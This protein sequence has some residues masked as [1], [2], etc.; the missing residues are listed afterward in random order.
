[1]RHL[2]LLTAFIFASALSAQCS[3]NVNFTAAYCSEDLNGFFLEFTVVSD[4]DSVWEAPQLNMSGAIN[5]GELFIAGPLPLSQQNT[6]IVFLMS[7]VP[8][9]VEV[10][11]PPEISCPGESC[12]GLEVVIVSNNGNSFCNDSL[13]YS[14]Q[15]LG[16]NA[17]YRLEVI[18]AN[19]V[20]VLLDEENFG[21]IGSVFGE[22]DYTVVATDEFDCEVNRTFT[23]LENDCAS[24]QGLSWLDNNGNGIREAEDTLSVNAWVALR[25][26]TGGFVG[27]T[28]TLSDGSYAFNGIMP[29]RTYQVS[30]TPSQGNFDLVAQ[31]VGNDLTV[32]SDF[33][34]ATNSSS[35]IIPQS[36]TDVL[37]IDAGWLAVPCEWNVNIDSVYCDETGD[38]FYVRF[39]VDGSGNDLW[40]A[41]QL[42]TEGEYGADF[43]RTEGPFALGQFT[44]ITFIDQNDDNCQITVPLP[45]VTCEDNPCFNNSFSIEVFQV[46][47]DQLCGTGELFIDISGESF[48]VILEFSHEATGEVISTT[49]NEPQQ[50]FFPDLPAG[51][52]FGTASNSAG[53]IRDFEI[54]LEESNNLEVGI[55]QQGS[56]CSGEDV[57]LIAEAFIGGDLT[58]EW[59]TGET[60]QLINVTDFNNPTYTV[61]VT[62]SD[63]CVGTAFFVINVQQQD[64]IDIPSVVTLSCDGSPTTIT[65]ANPVEGFTYQW[66]G[67][68]NEVLTG[69]S[70]ETDQAGFFEV[71]GSNGVGCS[72]FG[73]TQVIDLSLEEV[74]LEAT[75]IDS[76]CG[77]QFCFGLQNMNIFNSDLVDIT[78]T[79]PEEFNEWNETINVDWVSICVPWEGLYTVTVETEC[80]TISLSFET[81]NNSCSLISG[82][83]YLDADGDCDL[84]ADDIPAPGFIL[85]LT[86]DV[87]G[88]MYYAWTDADGNWA[89][90]LPLGTYTVEPI[91]EDGQPLGTCDPAT[92][93]T[94]GS[95]AVTGVQVFMPVL[96]NCP[97]L[98]TEVTIPFLRRC[99]TGCA[100]VNYENIGAGLAEDAQVV[101]VLDPFF[102]D[103]APSVAPVSVVGNVYTFNLGDLPPFSDGRIGFIFTVSCDAEIGQSHCIDASITPDDPCFPHEEWQGALVDITSAVCDGD[104]VT[105]TVTN[106]GDGQM[107]IPLNYVIVE[108]G[109]MLSA[110][111][112]TNGQLTPGEAFEITME[113]NG[114]TY[115]VITNQEPNAPG[116]DQP[117]AAAEGCNGGGENFST[118]FANILPLQSGNPAR[119]IVCRENVGSWDPNDKRGYP[120][121]WDDGNIEQGTRLDYEIRF[122]NTGTDTAFTVVI[123]D[124]LEESLDL[125]TFKM[126]ASSHDYTVT[127]DTHRVVS[128]TFENIMLPDSNANLLLSQGS[129][130]FS[131]DHDP[132]L[133]G[134][135]VILNEAAIYFD[136]N[137]PVIT[138]VSRHVIAKDG[139]PVG[140]RAITAQTIS[141]SIYPNPANDLINLKVPNQDIQ[142]TDVLTVTDL[143]GRALLSTTYGQLGRGMDISSLPA[144]YYLMLISD[145]SG[146]VMGRSGFVVAKN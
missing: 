57:I 55:V 115:A 73:F 23:V 121:G 69:T 75:N 116:N 48:P 88:A 113:A 105:F 110:Q 1:M 129:V 60:T 43:F 86:D 122:Q 4:Q 124:T 126:E 104:T 85:T 63:G 109:I 61:T 127:I 56:P 74:T 90:E 38:G 16:G 138:N 140:L 44:E 32:D 62:S 67:N 26:E 146:Q 98:Q 50:I 27:S 37:N 25:D 47:E 70:V 2:L 30:I 21:Q 145:Q 139:L 107:T 34:P 87:T 108:D 3:L 71:F 24:I 11:T 131:I 58:F 102:E 99:F 39:S 112:L 134:G 19:G 33:N 45:E 53:C 22:G 49:F 96:A 92:N 65:I 35:F 9:C 83:L 136:F 117:T 51:F 77:G 12:F 28:S 123:R 89:I 7:D 144:G 79:G 106:I 133:T 15:V 40:Y 118:G 64:T 36:G 13:F 5:T 95:E 103:V 97:V 46:L 52:Y 17:P 137:E 142:L 128:I 93:V 111:P 41:E 143:H 66:F 91:I 114:S 8:E 100:Y 81:G 31:F 78:W 119:S 125:A 84:D 94:L 18:D 68:S 72:S 54:F 10:V 132:S 80:E 59:S 120:L 29:N 141:M 135:D 76:I 101:V 20:T 82:T 42:G 130:I 14:F 6:A